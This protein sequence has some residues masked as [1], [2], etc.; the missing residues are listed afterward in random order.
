MEITGL[1]RAFFKASAL[2]GA[3]LCAASLARAST[4]TVNSTADVAANDGQCTLREAMTAANTNSASGAMAGECAAGQAF[5]TVDT[6]AFNISGAGVHTIAPASSLPAITEAVTIDGYTQPGASANTNAFP[7]ALNT[8]LLIELNGASS[9]GLF[10]NASGTTIR[11]L[12]INRGSDEV[13]INPSRNNVT[14]AGNFIGTNPTGTAA[15]PNASGGFAVRIDGGDNNVVGGPA[16]ADRNL[17]SGDLQG[18]V[19]VG[20]G[21]NDGTR[22]Q[23]NFIGPDVTGT[24]SLGNGIT[25]AGVSVRGSSTNTAIVDNLIS[26]NAAGAIEDGSIGG[27]VQGNLVGTQF[28]GTG[29][30]GNANFAVFGSGDGVTV[31]GSGAGQSNIIAFN[32][33]EVVGVVNNHSGNRISQNSIHDNTALGISLQTLTP[34]TPLLNDACDV[35]VVPGNLGQ[36]YPVITSASISAG[37]ATISGTLNSAASTAF[38]IEFFSNEFCHVSGH[39][40]GLTFLGFA[41]VTTDA[42]CNA[43]FGPLVFPVPSGQS[44]ITATA[45]DPNG[46]TSEFSVCLDAIAAPTPTPIPSV[47]PIATPVSPTATPVATPVGATPTPTPV[48]GGTAA[49]PTLSPFLLV[50]LAAALASVAIMLLAKNG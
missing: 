16:A 19:F 21:A 25:G 23:G 29:A 34:G 38:R 15:Q 50:L 6:I 47:T 24:I 48:V 12:V 35:D 49:V 27:V 14:I 30:L 36:N 42:A 7:N 3:F 40:E 33:S 41:N 4:I 9:G 43:S 1:S 18:G 32:T 31:G 37:N 8:V 11:G 5:P 45:T 46:N 10:V 39:G 13:E 26:G 17:L 22:I 2:S 44:V 20:L 28:D